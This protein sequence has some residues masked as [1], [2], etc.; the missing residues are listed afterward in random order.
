MDGREEFVAFDRKE[1]FDIIA[2]VPSFILNRD[3]M[4]S[5][6]TQFGLALVRATS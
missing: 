1:F 6:K 5:V 3:I 2:D 4:Q